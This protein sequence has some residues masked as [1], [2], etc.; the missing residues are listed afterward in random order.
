MH[1]EN[2]PFFTCKNVKLS[3]VYLKYL[4]K[5]RL[6]TPVSLSLAIR[7]EVSAPLSSRKQSVNTQPAR[8]HDQR[9]ELASWN[10]KNSVG[11]LLK[12]EKLIT[13]AVTKSLSLTKMD[14]WRM[15]R[16]CSLEFKSRPGQV[17]ICY[18]LGYICGLSWLK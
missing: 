15:S 4:E 2:C 16:P 13:T 1:L 7:W 11:K 8:H 3:L 10:V 18:R 6:T 17:N 14:Q 5:S 12:H 9:G